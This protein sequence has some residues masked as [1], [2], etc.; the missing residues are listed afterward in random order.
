MGSL[1]ADDITYVLKI[2]FDNRLGVDVPRDGSVLP[3]RTPA[4]HHEEVQVLRVGK[5]MFVCTTLFQGI[6]H[7]QGVDCVGTSNDVFEVV[8]SPVRRYSVRIGGSVL[9]SVPSS[10]QQPMFETF[11]VPARNVARRFAV[12]FETHD[13]RRDGL[14]RRLAAHSSHLPESRCASRHPSLSFVL[15]SRSI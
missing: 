11:N 3:S 8:S 1:L 15:A 9:P 5:L 2:E 4:L 7:N 10:L 12:C 14:M 6:E 13:G